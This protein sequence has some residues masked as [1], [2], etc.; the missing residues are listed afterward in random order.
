MKLQGHWICDDILKGWDAVN[1]AQ[2]HYSSM[3]QELTA[4]DF[5]SA[6]RSYF[7]ARS[8]L[9]RAEA[10]F[11]PVPDEGWV[12]QALGCKGSDVRAWVRECYEQLE[13]GLDQWP[14]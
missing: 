3:T 8:N 11:Q 7:Y 10:L 12:P 1:R 6:A 4:C 13:L 14:S 5:A 2:R 9:R